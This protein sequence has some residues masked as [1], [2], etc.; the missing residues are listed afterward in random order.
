MITLLNRLDDSIE[1]ILGASSDLTS[2]SPRNNEIGFI[3]GDI[4]E[5]ARF[6]LKKMGIQEGE[7]IV[8]TDDNSHLGYF[9]MNNSTGLVILSNK[10]M[11]ESARTSSEDLISRCPKMEDYSSYIY[12]YYKFWQIYFALM[13]IVREDKYNNGELDSLHELLY[14]IN[15]DNSDNGIIY[16]DGNHRN[17]PLEMESSSI[18]HNEACKMIGSTKFPK[19]L[20]RIFDY[21]SLTEVLSRYELQ[22]SPIEFLSVDICSVLKKISR[23]SYK[24]RA[25]MGLPLS[26]EGFVDLDT[27]RGKLLNKVL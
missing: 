23:L 24:K 9:D 27:R 15:L 18:A 17:L 8:F 12:N 19:K 20:L 21:I 26:W 10:K 22:K 1:I 3:D 5:I 7:N 2:V 13:H 25:N 16:F 4:L 11:N 6:F 14:Q